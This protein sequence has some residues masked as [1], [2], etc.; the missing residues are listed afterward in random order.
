MERNIAEIIEPLP[1]DDEVISALLKGEGVLGE[2]LTCVKAYEISDLGNA[3][4]R[5]LQSNDIF[6]ANIEAV[7]WANMVVDTL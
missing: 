7:S 5:N 3:H 4:F 2:A 1:L 6:V